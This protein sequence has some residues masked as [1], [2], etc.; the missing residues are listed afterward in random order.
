MLWFSRLN[1]FSNSDFWWLAG[2][3]QSM[4]IRPFEWEERHL[5]A[6]LSLPIEVLWTVK[7]QAEPYH[8][9]TKQDG[10][11]KCDFVKNQWGE[12]I[13]ESAHGS[14]TNISSLSHE[15]WTKR[16]LQSQ[17]VSRAPTL[18]RSIAVWAD[19]TSSWST[20]PIENQRQMSNAFR[21]N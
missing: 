20:I 2:I 7:S 15:I 1:D 3:V 4:L 13:Q 12:S 10:P 17:N 8:P 16:Q 9:N 21:Y 14:A 5:R 11:I 6:C 19:K 18:Y